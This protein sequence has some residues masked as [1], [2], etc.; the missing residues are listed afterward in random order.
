MVRS[1]FVQEPR[2]L[3]LVARLEEAVLRRRGRERRVVRPS[4]VGDDLDKLCSGDLT[5]PHPH[6]KQTAGCRVEL[7]PDDPR[8]GRFARV[9]RS[10]CQSEPWVSRHLRT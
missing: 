5:D 3:R 8:V 9:L 6:A 7:V 4:S 1:A 2:P 10:V